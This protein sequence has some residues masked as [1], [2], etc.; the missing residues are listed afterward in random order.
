LDGTD[1]Q[2]SRSLRN[3]LSHAQCHTI[4][5]QR[6]KRDQFHTITWKTRMSRRCGTRSP[7]W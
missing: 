6:S 7:W 3:R 2:V 5:I 4:L 1:A